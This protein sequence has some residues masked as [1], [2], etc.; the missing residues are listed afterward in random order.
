MNNNRLVL[1]KTGKNLISKLYSL[2]NYISLELD[3]II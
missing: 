1:K 3:Q 2:Q